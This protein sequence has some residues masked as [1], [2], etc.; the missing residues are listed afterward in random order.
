LNSPRTVLGLLTALN[1]LN[2]IDRNV[3]FG[4]QPLIQRE[5]HRSDAEMG[6][7]T[8]AFFIVYAF[9]A[10]PVVGPIADRFPRKLIVI[11]GAIIWSAA[12][13]LTAVTYDF[14]TLLFRHIIVG[15][16]EATFVVIAPAYI[17]DLFPE[18]R[19][20][21]ALAFFYLAIPVGSALGYIL[22]GY[23]GEHYG[24]RMP[25]LV[26]AAPGFLV[27]LAFLF[28][29]EP[30]RGQSDTLTSTTERSTI[31]GL[32]R[33]AA[34]WTAS[35]GIAM[36]T[37]ATG[38][39]QVWM[40]TFL[41]R[42]RGLPLDRAGLIFGAITVATGFAGT[43][44]G[45][46]LGDRFLRRTAGA[47]YLVSAIGMAL[48]LPLTALAIY[49]R[50]PAMFPFMAAAEFFIFLNTGP[51]N[52]AVVNSVAAPI[53]ATAIAVNLFV[54]HILGDAFSPTLM[55]YISDRTSL[56]TAFLAAMVAIALSAAVLFYGMRFAPRLT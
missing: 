42:M 12:T 4:V 50:G 48:A 10:G 28:T 29:T 8:T 11:A 32:A 7:L 39:M 19:R 31:F 43:L 13:L 21:R 40:P 20:G 47:Y 52:A 3:L 51:L 27:A 25:F 14:S 18:T 53:R 23:L 22:G 41:Y 15:V 46:W 49:T 30:L 5:F 45:G 26:G 6:F 9:L 24:W 37:F 35:L 33:N 56:E 38:G 1:F 36:L 44:I 34:Y 2:Y 16:G 54:I 17:A 55:G